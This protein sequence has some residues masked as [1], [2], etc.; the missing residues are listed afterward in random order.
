M[1]LAK[2][3]YEVGLEKLLNAASEVQVMQNE[4]IALHPALQEAAS[5]VK[6]IMAK[7][8]IESEDVAKVNPLSKFE[9]F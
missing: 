3:R 2:K 9:Y 6:E 8:E 1:L 5:N 7:V 4:L